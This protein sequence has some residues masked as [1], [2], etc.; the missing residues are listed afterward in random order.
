MNNSDTTLDLPIVRPIL[1]PEEAAKAAAVRHLSTLPL[2]PQYLVIKSG[3]LA[4][5]IVQSYPFSYVCMDQKLVKARDAHVVES[6]LCN[7]RRM[8]GFPYAMT[9]V[10]P[11]CSYAD[12]MSFMGFTAAPGKLYFKNLT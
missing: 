6:V 7:M 11:T 1:T 2:A 3:R 10:D 9:Y 8:A 5:T 12:R 4:G